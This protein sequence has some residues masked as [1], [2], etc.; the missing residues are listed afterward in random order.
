MGKVKAAVKKGLSAITAHLDI[1]GDTLAALKWR[2]TKV[3]GG[4]VTKRE[5]ATML[6]KVAKE[7]IDAYVAEIK[8]DYL[9]AKIAEDQAALAKMRG[10]GS[11]APATESEA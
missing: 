11:A 8:A 1:D 6:G 10:D 4:K 7:A 9:E 5:A 2:A 3:V